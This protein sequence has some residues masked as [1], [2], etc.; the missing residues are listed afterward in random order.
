MGMPPIAMLFRRPKIII[1]LVALLPLIF[2]GI[3]VRDF[4]LLNNTVFREFLGSEPDSLTFYSGSAGGVYD[5]IAEGLVNQKDAGFGKFTIQ[6]QKTRGSLENLI[7]VSRLSNSVTIVQADSLSQTELEFG[8]ANPENIQLIT[9]LYLEV[10]HLVMRKDYLEAFEKENDPTKAK[11]GQPDERA[12]NQEDFLQ[13]VLAKSII[14]TGPFL[15][16]TNSYAAAI[17]NA[18]NITPRQNIYNIELKE[19]LRLLS[20]EENLD[21]LF[22]MSGLP[23]PAIKQFSHVENKGKALTLVPVTGSF[24][25]VLERNMNLPSIRSIIPKNTY[26]N[27]VDDISTVGTPTR[28]IVSKDVSADTILNILKRMK[29]LGENHPDIKIIPDFSKNIE[30]AI[31]RYNSIRDA[32]KNGRLSRLAVFL[33]SGIVAWLAICSLLLTILSKERQSSFF[34][35]IQN[36]YRDDL[37][38]YTDLSD[39][40]HLMSHHQV[41]VYEGKDRLNKLVT[42]ISRLKK[43][44]K[45]IRESYSKGNLLIMDMRFLLDRVYDVLEIFHR[46]IIQHIFLLIREKA[47]ET[48]VVPDLDKL[49]NE[50]YIAGYINQDDYEWLMERFKERNP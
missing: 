19:G 20:K 25:R 9:P 36:I 47:D 21:A 32:E 5:T 23:V 37:G 4:P 34:V 45:Q 41:T 42:G 27:T 33:S 39:N 13:K 10:M 2:L 28:L 24:P 3:K 46:Q 1:G 50:H 15:S 14:S 29:I 40:Q 17:L 8:L 11:A 30:I 43:L 22:F 38:D 7:L 49:I 18:A 12:V 48:G 44:V 26:P 6:K 35:K 31:T 16:G